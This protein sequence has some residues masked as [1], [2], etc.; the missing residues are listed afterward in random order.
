MILNLVEVTRLAVI[1]Y[2]WGSYESQKMSH[3]LATP[4]LMPIVS[5]MVFG[6]LLCVPLSQLVTT[7]L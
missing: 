1:A 7:H 4:G 3:G 5:A 6:D 2:N